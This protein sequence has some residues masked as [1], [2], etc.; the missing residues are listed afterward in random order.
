MG[1]IRLQR[2]RNRQA[3][4]QAAGPFPYACEKADESATSVGEIDPAM[5]RILVIDDDADL[6]EVILEA[7][8]SAGHEARGATDGVQGLELQHERPADVVITDIFMPDKEGIETIRELKEQFPGVK[9]IAMSGGGHYVKKPGYLFT[10]SEIGAAMILRK[11]FDQ[12]ALLDSVQE[13][14]ERPAG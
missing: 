7:L 2:S 8:E 12:K 3:R 4:R 14:L 5:A 6:R 1:P 11:P 13:V 10:A 9:I